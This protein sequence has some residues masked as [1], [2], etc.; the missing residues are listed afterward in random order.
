MFVYFIPTTNSK[1]E[2]FVQELNSLWGLSGSSLGALRELIAVAGIVNE[3]VMDFVGMGNWEQVHTFAAK[4]KLWRHS[5][6]PHLFNIGKVT[7]DGGVECRLNVGAFLR[8]LQLEHFRNVQCIYIPCRK[9]KGLF[10]NDINK[11]A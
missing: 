10:V 3:K 8:F 6:L 1:L 9:T 2:K 11:R 5:S 4:C 7:M